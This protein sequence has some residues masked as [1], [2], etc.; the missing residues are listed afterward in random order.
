MVFV[1]LNNRVYRV[2]KYNMNRFRAVAGVE[3]HKGYPHLDLTDPDIDFVSVAEGFGLA[4]ERVVEES[5]VGPAVQRAFAA[6]RPYLLD[7]QIDGSV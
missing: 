1:I 6:G 4:A 7:V 3:E 2:L 5:E